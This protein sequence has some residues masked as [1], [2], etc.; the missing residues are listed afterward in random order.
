MSLT[1]LKSMFYF[2]HI[3]FKGMTH[4]WHHY[5]FA[6]R[7]FHSCFTLGKHLMFFQDF[8]AIEFVLLHNL[9]YPIKGHGFNCLNYK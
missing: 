5:H 7:D 4:N 6:K 9:D 2:K 1:N 3:N 8:R